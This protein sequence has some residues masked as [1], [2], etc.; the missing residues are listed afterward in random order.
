MTYDILRVILLVKW[1]HLDWRIL[2]VYNK[3][4]KYYVRFL[5]FFCNV[6]LFSVEPKIYFEEYG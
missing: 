6:F 2:D 4:T 5:I 3:K 1:M